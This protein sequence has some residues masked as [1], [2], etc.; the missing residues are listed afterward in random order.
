MCGILGAVGFSVNMGQSLSKIKHRGPDDYGEYY[1]KNNQVYLGH[2]RLSIIDLSP[3]GHQ[4][5]QVND[6]AYRIVYNGEIYNFKELQKEHLPDNIFVS[7]SD[8]E[9]L[10]HLY[11]KYGKE[12][13][14]Y[15]RGMFAYA[16]LDAPKN[17]I[18]LTRDRIGIKP[19]YYYLK[20]N[21]F[22]FASELQALK[23]IA[24]VDLE[25]DPIGLDYF[26]RYGYIPFPLSAYKYI[27][28]LSPGYQVIYNI[29]KR[30]ITSNSPFWQLKTE[31]ASQ[32]QLSENEWIER[33]ENKIREAVKLRLISDVPL[34]AFLSGG[35]DSTL[36]VSAMAGSMKE[37]VKT[38]T[39]GFDY[40]E[41]DER[42][43]A[44]EVA[45]KFG[46]E[47]YEDKVTSDALEILNILVESFGEPFMDPSAIPTYYV[48]Q[49][50]RKHVTVVLSG[51]GGD[52]IFA[53]YSRY[54]RIFR[55]RK[56][57]NI[58]YQIRKIISYLGKFLPES[59][60]GYGF[61]YRLEYSNI[62]LYR[63]ITSHITS[64]QQDKLYNP[65][66]KRA[67]EHHEKD[68]YEEL[69]DNY[70]CPENDLI[71]E[72]Q[73][74]DIHSYLPEDILTKVDRMSML[75]SLETRV[76]L[77]DHELVELALKC[78]SSIRFKNQD[79]KYLTK[80]MVI[81]NFDR[82]FVNRRKQGFDVPLNKWF[83]KEL[84]DYMFQTIE[85]ISEDDLINK[86]YAMDLFNSHQKGGRNFGRLLY[87]IL[88]Y[89]CWK[90]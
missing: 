56:F 88:F 76:P 75:H 52:E 37:P 8:T 58:P 38:F 66:F 78:P 29:D 41:Y 87:G 13:A 70:S 30:I 36:I 33:L 1:D 25:I 18:C 19:L 53:G 23:G 46:T 60:P 71:S 50:A 3:A 14:K 39:I 73:I 15:L 48:S 55:S 42:I 62:Q 6:G 40:N 67:L 72:M 44:R 77:L 43:Y 26:F 64:F 20:G 12:A 85:N 35:L 54:K 9:V 21:T 31:I 57:N 34:G 84:K 4:P 22:A 63:E 27:R 80:Q 81:K 2:R 16:V 68:Y 45:T 59:I 28:K 5:M 61:L 47:H 7:K 83:R 32:Y 10:L 74:I 65:D 51:D 11:V 89:K 86:E 49:M 79:L 69:L 17:E 82:K 90:S 24:G